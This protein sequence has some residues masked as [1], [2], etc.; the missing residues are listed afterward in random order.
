MIGTFVNE[1]IAMLGEGIEPATIE[2]AGSQAGYPAAPLQ[3]TD[4]LNMKLMQKIAKET[5]EAA[6]QGD[7]K[8]GAARHPPALDVID[9]MVEQGRPGRLE[10]A[11]FY[12]YDENGKRLGIWQACGITSRPLRRWMFRCR[13]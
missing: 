4:E 12:E 9:W 1:A 6:A 7:T 10:K 5:A 2:Q 13:T 3:L 11:G 8:M